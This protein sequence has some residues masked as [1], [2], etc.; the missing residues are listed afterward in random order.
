MVS[1]KWQK[2]CLISKEA[3]HWDQY[4]SVFCFHMKYFCTHM[5]CFSSF[6]NA[7]YSS[8]ILVFIIKPCHYR[9]QVPVQSGVV[10]K[11]FLL[12]V[13]CVFSILLSLTSSNPLIS[14]LQHHPLVFCS[15]LLKPSII[16]RF[17]V[18]L[19]IYHF[20]LLCVL[21]RYSPV[22][23]TLFCGFVFNYTDTWLSL[24]LYLLIFSFFPIISVTCLS[25]IVLHHLSIHLFFL[26]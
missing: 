25:F 4:T 23:H 21:R 2:I 18:S 7:F 26:A 3:T 12:Y 20:V 10:R 6:I 11:W 24:T 14:S 17:C 8:I 13:K 1:G 16:M 9:L 5:L 19:C 15:C 22:C